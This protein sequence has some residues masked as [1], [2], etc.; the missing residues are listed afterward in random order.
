MMRM[1]SIR[2]QMEVRIIILTIQGFWD[3][4]RFYFNRAGFDKY[5]KKIQIYF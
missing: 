5:G 4:D 1:T 2:H 3:P